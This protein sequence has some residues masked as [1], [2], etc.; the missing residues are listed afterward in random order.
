MNNLFR[1]VIA[2]CILC[3]FSFCSRE[4]MGQVRIGLFEGLFRTEEN[5]Y[6]AR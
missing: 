5:L 6:Q 2:S 4:I 3:L 1:S